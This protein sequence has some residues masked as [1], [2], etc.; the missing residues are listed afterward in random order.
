MSQ[1]KASIVVMDSTQHFKVGSRIA[2]MHIGLGGPRRK[3]QV[4]LTSGLI[5][6]FTRRQPVASEE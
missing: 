2:G 3:L 5:L 4:S 1:A 6:V